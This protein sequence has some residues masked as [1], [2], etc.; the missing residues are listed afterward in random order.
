VFEWGLEFYHHFFVPIVRREKG[1]G[2]NEFEGQ[3][4][5]LAKRSNSG[6]LDPEK[7]LFPLVQLSS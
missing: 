1:C 7:K 5:I 4:N 6:K 2:G 3:Y